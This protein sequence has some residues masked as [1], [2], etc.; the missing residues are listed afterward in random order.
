MKFITLLIMLF[1]SNIVTAT[2][3]DIRCTTNSCNLKLKSLESVSLTKWYVEGKLIATNQDYLDI[4][5]EWLEQAKKNGVVIFDQDGTKSTIVFILR[6]PKTTKSFGKS[7]QYFNSLDQVFIETPIN[8]NT[9]LSLGKDYEKLTDHVAKITS[10]NKSNFTILRTD[11]FGT[12]IQDNIITQ[13]DISTPYIRINIISKIQK[14]DYLL[15]SGNIQ[16]N[17]NDAGI[18]N[19]KVSFNGNDLLM[20]DKTFLLKT[21]QYKSRLHAVIETV[22]DDIII[23][24]TIITNEHIVETG[25]N[26]TVKENLL[27]AHCMSDNYTIET[28]TFYLGPYKVGQGGEVQTVAD[29]DETYTFVIEFV[30]GMVKK[31]Q[32]KIDMENSINVKEIQ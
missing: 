20:V 14:S 12:E 29:A 28:E 4:N 22:Y 7:G 16:T 15:I 30:E 23:D 18:K 32:I 2:V 24:S 5:I 31:Y 1:L 6:R 27:S 9:T 19:M 11:T 3:V 26:F 8:S 21:E 17:L 10:S 13:I 25:C